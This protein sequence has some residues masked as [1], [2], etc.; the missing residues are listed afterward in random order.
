M[1]NRFIMIQRTSIMC[2][3]LVRFDKEEITKLKD[4]QLHLFMIKK[5]HFLMLE[6]VFG[7]IRTQRNN[8]IDIRC[9]YKA[10]TLNF[11]S[12]EKLKKN[13]NSGHH[14]FEVGTRTQSSKVTHKWMNRFYQSTPHSVEKQM[15]WLSSNMTCSTSGLK[16]SLKKGWGIPGS[17]Q[18]RIQN[19]QKR[20]LKKIYDHGKSQE[21]N[22]LV[23]RLKSN[24]GRPKH[25]MNTSQWRPSSHNSQGEHSW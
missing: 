24:W 20:L 21:R 12:Y 13:L 11:S 23:Y 18:R 16:H 19:T 22:R 15:P 9:T 5:Y 14:K 10:C 17:V 7:T 1:S 25:R 2:G 3:N 6:T 4:T 8:E